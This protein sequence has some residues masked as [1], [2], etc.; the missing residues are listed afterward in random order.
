MVEQLDRHASPSA[1]LA[2]ASLAG[3]LGLAKGDVQLAYTSLILQ[4]A[5]IMMQVVFDLFCC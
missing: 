1:A 5:P 2:V 3:A 4:A